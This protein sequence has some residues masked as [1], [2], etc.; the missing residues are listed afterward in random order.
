MNTNSLV[1]ASGLSDRDLLTR[2]HAL[3]GKEREA[4]V[5][6]VAHL[7]V[8]DTRPA[9]YAAQSYGSLFGYCTKALRLSEDAACNRISGLLRQHV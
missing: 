4:T 2:I 5:E 9:L 8:L 3:A 7:A 1:A 6:L